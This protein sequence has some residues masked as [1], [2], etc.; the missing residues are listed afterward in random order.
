MKTRGAG[1]NPC[2]LSRGLEFVA[3]PGANEVMIGGVGPSPELLNYSGKVSIKC[4]ECHA[5][6]QRRWDKVRA[7]LD[8]MERG[9]RVV[10]AWRG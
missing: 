1:G 6:I 5:V 4:P 10:D 3:R 2:F 8:D 7:H 9:G